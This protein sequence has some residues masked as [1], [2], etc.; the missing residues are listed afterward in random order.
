MSRALPD[1]ESPEDPVSRRQPVIYFSRQLTRSILPSQRRV[2]KESPDDGS[3]G[4]PH[5]P[6]G[7][8]RTMDTPTMRQPER[9]SGP[10]TGPRV[11]FF[12]NLGCGNIG[13][14]TSMESVLRFLRT[15][16]PEAS[17]DAMCKG[18]ETV[19]D[20]YCIP[21]TMMNWYQR[22]ETQARGPSAV[23]LKILGKGI[24]VYSIAS[25]VRRHDVVIV[26]GMG[27]MEASLPLPPWHLPYSFLLLCS[28]A[29][30]FGTKVAF[31]SVGA[32]SIKRRVTRWFLDASARLAAYRSYRDA[33]SREAMR[34]RG[35][36]VSQDHVFPDLVFGLPAIPSGPGDP[37]IVGVGVMEFHG[38]NDDRGEAEA[39]RASYVGAM[40]SFVRW[41]IDNDRHVR[42]LI[43]Q[44]DNSDQAV[45]EEIMADAHAYRPDID[46]GH[47][48]LAASTTFTELMEAMEPA[49]TVVATR[50]HNVIC[51]LRLGKPVISLGYAPKFAALMEDMGLS[52]FCQSAKSVDVDKLIAQFNELERREADLRQKIKACNAELERGV[53]SQFAELSAELFTG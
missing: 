34:R 50:F 2:A 27:T 48:M 33:P 52:E 9:R 8:A 46:P 19:S 51:A 24:D 5:R 49:A 23:L 39:I 6:L 30:V 21:A 3:A 25:W 4:L 1:D 7:A 53:A 17:I 44:S 12:G 36:D 16:H 20:R 11:G 45:A 38:G 10:H 22:Y 41:L 18:P 15:D 28:S 13:N 42:L 35:L 40:K 37:Q 32:G 31:V 14:D 26:P 43:G 29:R 47:I